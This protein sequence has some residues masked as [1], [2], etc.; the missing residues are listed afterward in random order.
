MIYE[1][2]S[3]KNGN[4]ICY[5]PSYAYMEDVYALFSETHPEICTK[6]Q[7]RAMPEAERAEFL[8]VF[9]SEPEETLLG[10]CVMGGIFSEGIDLEG[11]RLIGTVIVGVGL[12]QINTEL[13]IVRDYYG[14]SG[15][16]FAY[17]FPGMNK[18]LQ[19]AGRV[20]RS[21]TD[22][23]VVLLIDDRFGTYR[24]ETLFPSHWNHFIKAADKD[25][26]VTALDRFWNGK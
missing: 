17:L 6:K 20:I 2:V 1:T 25:A 8:S 15:Y 4:Y 12:P 10:F 11:D 13:D 16:D 26:L 24:Y 3:R 23:G 19:A 21:E 5:F 18:V 22:V 9:Q 14:R 7:L